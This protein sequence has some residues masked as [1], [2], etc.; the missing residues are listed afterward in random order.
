MKF[1]KAH[2][3]L[4]TVLSAVSSG[5]LS[6]GY[7][8][9]FEYLAFEYFFGPELIVPKNYYMYVL[10]FST[11]IGLLS[12]APFLGKRIS[13]DDKSSIEKNSYTSKV[14]PSII[15]FILIATFAASYYNSAFFLFTLPSLMWIPFYII[16]CVFLWIRWY[17]IFLTQTTIAL[18]L[19]KKKSLLYYSFHS[20][21]L[22][23]SGFAVTFP[24][25]FEFFSLPT[26]LA[27]LTVRLAV[28]IFTAICLFFAAIKITKKI[29][30]M[31]I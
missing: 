1:G 21:F 29:N 19:L 26:H 7:A 14:L 31:I 6:Y 9:V 8:H 25:I 15:I 28:Y 11:V 23:I 30:K 2:N 10:F 18:H 12:C 4:N 17:A 27:Y 22:I 24:L 5:F 16:I 20:I 3:S 13:N